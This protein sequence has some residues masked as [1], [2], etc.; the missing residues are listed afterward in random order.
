MLL[1][2]TYEKHVC[3]HIELLY[4]DFTICFVSKYFPESRILH[5][6]LIFISLVIFSFFVEVAKTK[7]SRL[8]FSTSMYV[9][10]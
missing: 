9:K 6:Y 2:S 1:K 3:E 7:R 5:E 10:T 8:L 4:R